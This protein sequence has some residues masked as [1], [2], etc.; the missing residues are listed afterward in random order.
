MFKRLAWCAAAI[1]AH[2]LC[3]KFAGAAGMDAASHADYADGWQAGDNG[4][5]GFGP[6]SFS[7]SGD[8]SALVHPAPRFIATAPLAGNSLPTPAFALTTND[9]PLNYDTSAVGRQIGPLAV[10]DTLRVD[11]DGSALDN[12]AP[13]F[14]TGNTV[15]LL[16]AD[17]VERF[18]LFTNNRFNGNKWTTEGVA[19]GVEAA[20]AFTLE[21][22]LTAADSYDVALRPLGGG[23]PLYAL[24]GGALRGTAGAAITRI[25]IST[26][27]TGSSSDGTKE[28]FFN[29]LLVQSVGAAS[30]DFD[31]DTD[32]DGDDLLIWQR[33]V[34]AST[35][36]TRSQGDADGDGNVDSED[37]TVWQSQFGSVPLG[38]LRATSHVP[39]PY[40]GSLAV[41]AFA[42]AAH[43]NARRQGDC[44]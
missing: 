23:A 33:G 1:A 6:W 20:S 31:G 8:A 3:V 16:A 43:L 44:R 40:G 10:G 13:A 9:R 22:T 29:N 36:A 21:F 32:V 15:Q 27:G 19:T 17:G 12:S 5:S 7:F 30:A 4:G 34:G 26:F 28:L 38:G 42:A 35:G 24:S 18:G 37:R 25:R 2:A 39:E 14:S 41:L 11:L